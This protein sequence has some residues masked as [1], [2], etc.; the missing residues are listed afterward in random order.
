MKGGVLNRSE[1]G[2]RMHG[3]GPRWEAVEWLFYTSCKKLGIRVFGND[4]TVSEQE[5]K[6]TTFRRPSAQLSLFEQ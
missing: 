6:A 2:K 4:G 1:F 3:E 5:A